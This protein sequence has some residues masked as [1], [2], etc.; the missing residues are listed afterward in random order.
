MFSRNPLS[1]ACTRCSVRLPLTAPRTV[2]NVCNLD[3]SETLKKKN[4]DC[5]RRETSN[6][7]NVALVAVDCMLDGAVT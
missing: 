1:Q 7:V 4:I 6:T 5:H 3:A 2:L